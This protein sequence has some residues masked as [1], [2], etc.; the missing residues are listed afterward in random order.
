MTR[1]YIRYVL[2]FVGVGF[3]ADRKRL[4]REAKYRLALAKL[5]NDAKR[6]ERLAPILA[7]GTLP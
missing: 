6:R 5:E 2:W 7:T 1:R 4:E 3:A